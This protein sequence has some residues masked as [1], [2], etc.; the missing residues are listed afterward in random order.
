MKR[1]RQ[2]DT[3]PVP[4]MPLNIQNSFIKPSEEI[5]LKDSSFKSNQMQ[6]DINNDEEKAANGDMAKGSANSGGK[7][8]VKKTLQT[9]ITFIDGSSDDEDFLK[10]L[11]A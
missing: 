6:E 10:S 7:K 1:I 3:F 2:E 8:R 11:F 9:R 4:T 5:P